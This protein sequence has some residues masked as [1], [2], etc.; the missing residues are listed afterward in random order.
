MSERILISG[1]GVA[2]CSLAWWLRRY[3]F[4]VTVVEQA[5]QPRQGGYVIDFWGRG[6]DI[7][8]RMGLI[9]QL[10][11]QGLDI[12]E[13]RIVNAAG[14]RVSGLSV[15]SL[16]R[17]A[18]GRLLSLRRSDL[19]LGLY[20]A[21]QT[22]VD[23]R[24]ND[25]IEALEQTQDGVRVEFRKG[26]AAGYDMVIGADGLHSRIRKL[27]FGEQAE[28]ERYL[29]Y[30]AAAFTARGYR[31]RD[32]HAY[33]VYGVP[34]RQIARIAATHD[35]TVFL[36]LF[37]QAQRLSLA[38]DDIQAQKDF[39]KQT[40]QEVGWEGEAM[41]EAMQASDDLYFD[42]VSQIVMPQWRQ[43]R[44]ALIGDACGAVSLVAG[45]GSALAMTEAYVLA[46]ELKRSAGDHKQAFTAYQSSL[47]PLI[48]RKQKAAR[49]LAR[50]FVP[51]TSF[52]LWARNAMTN[53]LD[54]TGAV[55]LA[56]GGSLNDR[57]TLREY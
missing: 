45:Q 31:P 39:L 28:F 11:Q 52:D 44:V 33:T 6:Y 38:H 1:A 25:S 57:Y 9:P 47:Q 21:V 18:G 50:S 10:K 30:H 26:E 40:F 55:G 8:E 17:A 19:A 2:G 13:L 41:L 3:G 22:D 49:G 48:K 37:H 15:R 16:L 35:E 27:V 56:F 34:G 23:W 43:G 20:K 53:L 4:E 42:P 36:L 54:A 14:R 5:A 24:F 46:G 51:R 32:E 12:H 7:A 29:G